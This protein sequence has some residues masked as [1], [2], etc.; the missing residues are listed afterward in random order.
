MVPPSF[1]HSGH[2]FPVL[3]LSGNV[4]TDTP[5]CVLY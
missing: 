5:W 2:I 4:L 1:S 3:I